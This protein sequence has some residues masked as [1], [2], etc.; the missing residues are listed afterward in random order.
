MRERRDA[1]AAVEF[2]V[3]YATYSGAEL[4]P[5]IGSML[6]SGNKDIITRLALNK[7]LPSRN[8]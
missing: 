5:F 3:T 8:S 2:K 6:R 1:S 4:R 7:G